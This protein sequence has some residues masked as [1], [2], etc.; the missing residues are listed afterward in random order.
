MPKIVLFCSVSLDGHFEGVDR[1][2]SWSRVDEEVHRHFNAELDRLGGFVSG[3]VTHEL[4]ADYWPTAESDPDA[5]PAMLEFAR[6]WRD[7][8]KTVFSRTLRRADWNTTVV[9]EVTPETVAALKAG[10]AGDL[11]LSGGELAAAFRALDLIDEYRIYVHP[12]LLGRGRQLFPVTD[13]PA[14]LELLD[15]RRFTN[16]V[17]LLHY[18]RAAPSGSNA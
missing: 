4:M 10:A 3:R 2:I 7:K 9:S 12:V 15:T 17:V 18:A 16:G 13:T 6:I 11:S 1:D 5:T 8:P 14:D